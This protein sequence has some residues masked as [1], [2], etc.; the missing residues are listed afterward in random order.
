MSPYS[1]LGEEEE[2]TVDV[3]NRKWLLFSVLFLP[4]WMRVHYFLESPE[5]TKMKLFFSFSR[6][7][8]FLLLF[9]LMVVEG[10]AARLRTCHGDQMRRRRRENS[11]MYFHAITLVKEQKCKW[12]PIKRRAT[13]FEMRE[14]VKKE[15]KRKLDWPPRSEDVFDLF[16]DESI[17]VHSGISIWHLANESPVLAWRAGDPDKKEK[18]QQH[19][20]RFDE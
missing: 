13:T 9:F 2:K 20:A 4:P 15:M 14:C 7:I 10:M 18:K 6:K 3:K 19:Y 8:T 17:S 16:C 5:D 12:G 11:R 1:D